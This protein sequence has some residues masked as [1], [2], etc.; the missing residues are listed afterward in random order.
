MTRL[1]IPRNS[2]ERVPVEEVARLHGYPPGR[3]FV[4]ATER[5][6]A[7]AR[8]WALANGRPAV[9]RVTLDV[10]AVGE[11]TVEWRSE[12]AGGRFISADLAGAL[13]RGAAESLV[14]LCATVGH[15]VEEEL[16][17]LGTTR[18]SVEAYFLDRFAAAWTEWLVH[19]A[20]VE[21]AEAAAAEGGHLLPPRSP[22]REDWDLREQPLLFDAF[23]PLPGI[24]LLASGM[25]VPRHSMLTV[26]GRSPTP[27]PRGEDGALPC[28]TCSWAPCT[29]RRAPAP[30][31]HP[32]E[33]GK[34]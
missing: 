23:G 34:S 6:A 13:A 19:W 4:G 2:A 17:R 28:S 11:T 10:V 5:M 15:E 26:L 27:S 30:R 29:F 31:T 16:V 8:D 3:P 21:L 9:H 32:S 7:A 14:G 18:A 25:L 24:E 22:G 33:R 1:S 20:E 12:R